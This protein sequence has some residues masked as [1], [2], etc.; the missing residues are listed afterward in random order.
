[1]PAS[2]QKNKKSSKLFSACRKRSYFKVKL[3]NLLH[4]NFCHVLETLSVKV[5]LFISKK[6]KMFFFLNRFFNFDKDGLLEKEN[7]H[8]KSFL[9]NDEGTNGCSKTSRQEAIKDRRRRRLMEWKIKV[10][11]K[12]NSKP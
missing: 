11:R 7:F 1:M 9:S 6:K 3:L 5:K 8:I 12:H 4:S 2:Q 10:Y